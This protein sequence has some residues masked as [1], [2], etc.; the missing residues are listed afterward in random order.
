AI[1]VV[2]YIY[3]GF[4][5]ILCLIYRHQTVVLAGNPFKFRKRTIH[6]V[7]LFMLISP[8]IPGILSALVGNDRETIE[9]ILKEDP[10]KLSWIKERGSYYMQTRTPLVQSPFIVII[11]ILTF[12]SLLLIAVFIHMIYVLQKDRSKR[13]QQSVVAIRRSLLNLSAQLL[14]PMS[15]FVVPATTIF[16]GLLFEELCSFETLLTIFLVLPTHSIGH[17]LILLT[18]TSTYRNSI[19][20]CFLKPRLKWPF[21]SRPSQVSTRF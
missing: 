18:I 8:P 14:I 3:T 10:R 9:L 21:T 11:C 1:T 13:S 17:N 15:L 12:G 2:I 5:I 16:F 20:S 19:V 4:V 6:L 7:H